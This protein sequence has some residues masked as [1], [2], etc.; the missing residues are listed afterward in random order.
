VSRKGK[1]D[2]GRSG[3][4]KRGKHEEHNV[5]SEERKKGII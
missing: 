4:R 3:K 5:E 1:E 2:R